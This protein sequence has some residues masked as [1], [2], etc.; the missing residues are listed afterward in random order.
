MYYNNKKICTAISKII[1]CNITK[2][3]SAT[4][5][6]HIMQNRKTYTAIVMQYRKLYT[7][8]SQ[9]YVVQ[10]RKNIYCDIKKIV[11]QY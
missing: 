1:Y 4:S 7:A 8:T 6:K 11:M 5:R 10:H 9:K 3:S 2:I